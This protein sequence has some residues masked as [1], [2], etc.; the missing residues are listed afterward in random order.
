M[1]RRLRP[2]PD[3]LLAIAL[4]ASSVQVEAFGACKHTADRRASIDTAGATGVVVNARA[5][6]LVLRPTATGTLAAAGK[7][8]AS[9]EKFLAETSV[10]VRREGGTIRVD[11]MVPDQMVG[12]GVFYASLDLA[13]DVPHGLPVEV[14]DSSGDVDA[15]GIKLAKIT[16]SSGDMRLRK[17]AGDVEVWDSS[18]DIRIED[19]AG[20]V[21]VRDSSGDIVVVGAN[22]VIIPSDSSGD[23]TIQRI[24]GGVQVEQD[25]SGDIRITDV[26]GD[27]TVL[28]DSSGEVKV[29][30]VRGRVQLP[31]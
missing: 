4:L 13:V 6:D 28:G 14:T 2:R 12:I 10:S 30:A 17:L 25:S 26:G 24:R 23:M 27:V 9:S 1:T 11:V 7:A 8:C 31:D 3:L 20:R 22:E 29:S 18:G 19:V 5:G 15:T 16:D 21:Q